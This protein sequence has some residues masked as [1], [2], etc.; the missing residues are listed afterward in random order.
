M[1]TGDNSGKGVRFG[2]GF[3][4]GVVSVGLSMTVFSLFHGWYL[5]AFILAVGC[6]CGTL[7]VQHGDEF[8]EKY[9]KWGWW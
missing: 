5:I 8:F 9:L 6:I 2:C 4:L 7:A 1:G 3:F